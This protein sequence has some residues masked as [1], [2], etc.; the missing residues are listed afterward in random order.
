M[1]DKEPK[2]KNPILLA[3]FS[4]AIVFVG[5]KPLFDLTPDGVSKEVLV[6][7][8]GA[9]FVTII[10]LVL[11]KNQTDL[12]QQMQAER[13]RQEER[14]KRSEQLRQGKLE[15]YS[16]ALQSLEKIVKGEKLSAQ[17]LNEL[18]FSVFKLQLIG[19][20]GAYEHYQQIL[21]TLAAY[22]GNQNFTESEVEIDE[23]TMKQIFESAHL[24]S[25]NCR[26][27]EYLNL[28][29]IKDFGLGLEKSL[30][31][32]SVRKELDGGIQEYIEL[33][34]ISEE[35]GANLSKVVTTLENQVGLQANY[36]KTQISLAG[37]TTS[38]KRKNILYLNTQKKDG[39]IF[40]IADSTEEDLAT[41][42]Q[43]QLRL[44]YPKAKKKFRQDQKRYAVEIRLPW[45]DTD[46]I[47]LRPLAECLEI[48][49][50]ELSLKKF[51]K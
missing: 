39:I 16:E 22:Y 28:P 9:L 46:T 4:A 8:I 47:D 24:F 17:N 25:N 5:F 15:A 10:T 51:S 13:S 12:Q 50:K 32:V 2:F 41:K 38:E 3:A 1:K 7:G 27:D 49:L 21:E 35:H 29:P 34:K 26:S 37:L 48:T 40:T 45:E 23:S 44:H 11:L 31:S 42:V 14:Q 19:D 20:S 43:Q 30:M 18:R 33:H 6:A 36:K